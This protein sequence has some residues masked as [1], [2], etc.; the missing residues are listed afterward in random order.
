MGGGSFF[1]EEDTTKL[2]GFDTT[3]VLDIEGSSQ[4]FL[5]ARKK[6]IDPV[7]FIDNPLNTFKDPS[8]KEVNLK[9]YSKGGQ[10]VYDF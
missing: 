6:V 10:Q 2:Q 7:K 3:A 4:N 9:G 5:G 8:N 1:K